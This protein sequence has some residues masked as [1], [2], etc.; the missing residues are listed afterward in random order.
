MKIG[1]A[2]VA[3][4]GAILLPGCAGTS[5]GLRST[6]SP[7]LPASAFPAGSSGSPVAIQAEV[8]PGTYFGLVFLGYIMTAMQGEYPRWRYDPSPGR[9]PEL[10]EDRSVIERDCS[11]P[12]ER[13]Y[14]NLRCK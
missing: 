9:P 13:P 7:S 10:D 5:I 11:R 14:A 4:I 12:L 6:N 3:L 8:N 1:L 2:S